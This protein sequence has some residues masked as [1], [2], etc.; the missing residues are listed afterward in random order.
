MGSSRSEDAAGSTRK[1]N[2]RMSERVNGYY[3][4]TCADVAL[5]KRGVDPARPREPGKGDARDGPSAVVLGQNQPAP[6]GSLLGSKLDL[7]A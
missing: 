7:R 1:Q 2:G 4:R 5:A 3:C 6:D